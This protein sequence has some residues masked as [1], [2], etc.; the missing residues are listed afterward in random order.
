MKDLDLM[1]GFKMAGMHEGMSINAGI[2][3]P[4]ADILKTLNEGIEPGALHAMSALTGRPTHPAL[5]AMALE[6]RRNYKESVKKANELEEVIK[7]ELGQENFEAYTSIVNSTNKMQS[8][9][10][11]IYGKGQLRR[12]TKEFLNYHAHPELIP[13]M[14]MYLGY[15][16]KKVLAALN[17]KLQCLE[18]KLQEL[19]CLSSALKE[20]LDEIERLDNLQKGL[21]IRQSSLSGAY[22]SPVHISL[23]KGDLSWF[24]NGLTQ[25][26]REA[27]SASVNCAGCAAFEHWK[28]SAETAPHAIHC[29]PDMVPHTCGINPLVY[30]PTEV[31]C[32]EEH[33]EELCNI[34]RE[35][36]DS[37]PCIDSFSAYKL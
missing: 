7:A 19:A 27:T 24:D 30:N 32:E 34:L 13:D 6:K 4:N 14:E 12:L 1:P 25:L 21:K 28:T 2:T 22:A 16:L 33:E 15:T 31:K 18:L 35:H 5:F 26:C 10:R 36:D 20:H 8:F 11:N 17:D 29:T 3:K 9:R 37:L 23:E